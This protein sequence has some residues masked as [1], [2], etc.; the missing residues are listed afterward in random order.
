M[1][2]ATEATMALLRR[3]EALADK[4]E[5]LEADRADLR[6]A[7]QQL[8]RSERSLSKGVLDFLLRCAQ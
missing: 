2:D 3:V 6:A 1:S 7:A 4:S 5:R 8:L